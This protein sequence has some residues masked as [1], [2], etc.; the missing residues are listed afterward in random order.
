[1]EYGKGKGSS[2]KD[3][4]N[5][6]F[7]RLTAIKPVSRDKYNQI[8][9]LCKYDCGNEK[10]IRGTNLRAGKSSSCGCVR[11]EKLII[12]G[13]TNKKLWNSSIVI[14]DNIECYEIP[15]TQN[16]FA[17]IDKEDFDLI[18]DYKWYSSHGYAYCTKEHI[19]MHGLIITNHDKSK[20][21]DH[22][23]RN[24]LDNRKSNLRI[25][26][27]STNI[28]NSKFRNNNT[29]GYKGIS[30]RKS[31]NKYHAYGT[32]KNKFYHLGYYG[33]IKDAI[34]ARLNWEKEFEVKF[35]GK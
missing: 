30:L 33:D 15:L 4:T 32:Y 2:I 5:Q 13:Q 22:I 24:T 18:K 34:K 1:M 17:I 12:T 10:L 20:V 9:W 6:K 14:I 21:I 27:I 31:I 11:I 25:V 16:K 35:Y 8:L 23:N 19:Y 28:Y 29:S 7:G 26:S 3:I